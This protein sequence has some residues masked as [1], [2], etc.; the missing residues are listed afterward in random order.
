MTKIYNKFKTF[1]IHF[2]NFGVQKKK[3]IMENPAVT[4]NFIWVSSS[5]TKFRKN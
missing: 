3:K 2:P 5:M 1:F 4:H